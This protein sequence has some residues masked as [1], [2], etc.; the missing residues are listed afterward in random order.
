MPDEPQVTVIDTP[1]PDLTNPA[2]L[3]ARMI[4]KGGFDADTLKKMV[5]M[6]EHHEAKGAEKAFARAMNECQQKLPRVIKG[7][8]GDRGLYATLDQIQDAVMPIIYEHG[9]SITWSQADAKEAGLTRVTAVL[10]HTAG[11]SRQYQ[12]DYAI[13]GEGAKGGRVMN[14]LQGRVSSHTYAQR[15]MLRLMW[16]ITISGTDLDGAQAGDPLDQEQMK[17]INGLVDEIEAISGV[18]YPLQ[19]MIDWMKSWVKVTSDGE[20]LNGFSNVP[21]S[22][23]A[24][25]VQELTRQRKKA[26]AKR[27]EA[28]KG[29]KAK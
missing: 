4:E 13:D 19:W 27:T 6:A 25:I 9:F 7:T 29:G 15:D 23:F 11:H 18:T 21:G 26:T 10:F 5:D 2:V 17:C 3:V 24:K 8:K 14:P 20:E 22:A 1:P 28:E 16:N 12:G